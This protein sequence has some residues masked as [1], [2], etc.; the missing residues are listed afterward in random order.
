MIRVAYLTCNYFLFDFLIY[1]HSILRDRK[2]YFEFGH[3]DLL[4]LEVL[5]VCMIIGIINIVVA[6]FRRSKAK[7]A[8]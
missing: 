3:A 2:I 1:I 8:R 7:D 6:I 5:A 4:L